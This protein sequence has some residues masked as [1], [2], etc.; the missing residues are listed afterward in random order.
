MTDFPVGRWKNKD[1]RMTKK[2]QKHLGKMWQ[3]LDDKDREKYVQMA[4]DEKAQFEK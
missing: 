2:G 3:A 1:G 4:A